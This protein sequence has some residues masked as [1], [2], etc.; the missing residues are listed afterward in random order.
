[1][2]RKDDWST[3]RT[4]LGRT[5]LSWFIGLSLLPLTIVGLIEYNNSSNSIIRNK[6]D[7]LAHVNLLLSRQIDNYHDSVITNL[8]F[9]A[10]LA[11]D[12]LLD[13]KS[14]WEISDLPLREYLAGI[15]YHE[16]VEWHAPEFVDF[17]Y[18]FKYSD[19]QLIDEKGNI[20]YTIHK[21]REL[22][23]NL[24]DGVLS[25]TRL[26]ATVKQVLESGEPHYSDLE[27]Y[28]PLGGEVV[29]FF[30]MPLINEEREVAG[31]IAVQ[32]RSQDD[33]KLLLHQGMD[34]G[35][36]VS[37]YIV[38]VDGKVRFWAEEE[39][40]FYG[41]RINTTAVMDWLNH[42]DPISGE[43]TESLEHFTEYRDRQ[44]AH[45]E[46]HNHAVMNDDEHDHEGDEDIL[47]DMDDGTPIAHIEAYSN[48]RGDMVLGVYRHMEIMGTP[49]VLLTEVNLE[50]ALQPVTRFRNQFFTV[51]VITSLVVLLISMVST[52]RIAQPL[53][54]INGWVNRVASGEYVKG[55]V[56]DQ[57][58]EIGQLSRS[59]SIMT[60]QLRRVSAE[61][62]ARSWL[63]SGITGLNEALRGELSIT[64]LCQNTLGFMCRYLRFQIGAMYVLTER[65][66]LVMMGS[67]AYNMS[68]AHPVSF[69]IGEGLPGQA[70]EDRQTMYV[71]VPDD[72]FTIASG[73]GSS[74]PDRVLVIP[75]VF[76]DVVKGVL[77]FGLLG[78][79]DDRA[80][81][82][83]D[84]SLESIAIVLNRVQARE[85]VQELLEQTTR[86][87]E[88]LTKQQDDLRTANQELEHQTRILRESEEEL[89]SQSEELQRANTELEEK[90]ESLFRQ[91]AEI[92]I[93]TAE[94]EESRHDLETKA[95]ELEEASRYKSEFL[96]NMSHELRTPLNSMLILAR[97]L[98][99]ND[100]GNLSEDEVESAQVID[101]VGHDLLNLINEILDLSKVEAGKL[102]LNL[103]DVLLESV[104]RQM[105]DQ[106]S[107]VAENKGL[108]YIV[109][110]DSGLPEYL[111]SDGQRLMQVIKN[112][113][114]NAIKFTEEGSVTLRIF[115]PDD[116]VH[117]ASE[118]LKN[119]QHVIG[120]A[121]KDTGI[122]IPPEKQT[123]I[124]EAFQQ[125]DGSTSR[126]YGGTGLG[127]S[128]SREMSVLLGGEMQITSEAGKGA[129][130]TLYVTD[131]PRQA[132]D[133]EASD[134]DVDDDMI[135]LPE[136]NDSP[137]IATVS[138]ESTVS[139]QQ[140]EMKQD[141]SDRP[142]L[143]VE[144][145]K[146][147]A[148]V[149]KKVAESSGYE[150]MTA[151]SGKDALEIAQKVHP[152]AV[153][154]DL[155]LPDMD[156]EQVLEQLK[157]Q[158]GNHSMPV[159]IIS[160]RE[161]DNSLLHK[162]ATALLKKP[163]SEEQ[164][165]NLFG[166]LEKKRA[167]EIQKVLI[168]DADEESRQKTIA[169]LGSRG[170]ETDV[171]VNGHDLREALKKTHYHCL[172]IDI[173]LPDEDGT[174]LLHELHDQLGDSMPQ[175]IIN[176]SREIDREEHR[177]LAEFAG[178]MVMKGEHS[179]DRLVD[180]VNLFLHS[181]Q[182][183]KPKKPVAKPAAVDD[184]ALN[185]RKILLVDDD[186]RNTF[187]L[188]KALQKYHLEIVLAD[189]GELALQQLE[190]E[191]D[192][193]L[194]LMDIMMPVMDGYEATRR[195]RAHPRFKNLPV[196][197]LTAKAMSDDRAKCIE[198]GAN[199]YMTKPID[200]EKMVAMLKLWLQQKSDDTA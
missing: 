39:G 189:N 198:A 160:G 45:G 42:I 185:G 139:A 2:K 134:V 65:N 171:V 73:L 142:L 55:E 144:D 188:S 19:I 124:F 59:F 149:L 157:Q 85:R 68:S 12:F 24:F 77:E 175:V 63:Q 119:S 137:A 114:S 200:M 74:Q 145:D 83:I 26:S 6:Q 135:A 102:I 159:H 18:F 129:T 90:T 41:Q 123:A 122:G 37:S 21:Y 187:A 112:L 78:S 7:E 99:D 31:T 166:K 121:V 197:A 191:P 184:S 177:E 13:L 126:K 5:L 38:G 104:E 79:V 35:D 168:I 131:M 141:G 174:A 195:I 20:L 30:V 193:E 51:L 152:Q 136:S 32:M 47:E 194:V 165:H 97:M 84:A 158:T 155:G 110:C 76:D 86:Q 67:Y 147:F 72:Y 167:H 109:T 23:E 34:T 118:N 82:F 133:E 62:E 22:G 3:Y 150:C 44:D 15:Q 103:E 92:E 132:S 98:A 17:L 105:R 172:V 53:V 46:K 148:A 94:I 140:V 87:T 69:V 181:I 186:L 28:E 125:A 183:G 196:I 57:Q 58:N 89:K 29:S 108:D 33:L 54:R 48:Y 70:A 153:I 115:K 156:G 56:I 179:E 128:I 170:V 27:P 173:D 66:R 81:Q 143:I 127:L 169:M 199:D 113:L 190:K 60:E 116:D 107:A 61:N 93:K 36:H 91:K 43:Y 151:H 164:L 182:P 106:F 95:Q 120:F 14:S 138:A 16:V 4:G 154:L 100:D 176:T 9:R 163:V 1:M 64:E 75:I 117:F 11:M 80:Q 71:N 40:L 111:H 101:M 52:R 162:G 88:V 180:E 192:V 130:F 146:I 8:F 178:T 96:A 50:D 25:D 49:M 161:L 10:G